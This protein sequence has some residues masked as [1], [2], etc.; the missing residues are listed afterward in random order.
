M[1][2]DGVSR[3]PGRPT[4]VKTRIMAGGYQATGQQVVR[5]DREP[6]GGVAGPAEA[7]L[8]EGL[9]APGAAA[10]GFPGPDYGYGATTP[11]GYETGPGLGRARP[12]PV[13]IGNRAQ[14]AGV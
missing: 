11:R 10:D 12:A 8:I 2:T 5:L 6:E 7:R 9:R 14:L 3:E 13:G 1:S 4:P